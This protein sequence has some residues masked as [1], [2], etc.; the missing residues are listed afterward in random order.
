MKM[1]RPR[2]K[3]WHQQE[4][5]TLEANLGVLSYVYVGGCEVLLSVQR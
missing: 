2:N 3:H 5:E 4:W 1:T